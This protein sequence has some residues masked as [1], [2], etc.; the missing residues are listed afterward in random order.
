MINQKFVKDLSQMPFDKAARIIEA[1]GEGY[2]VDCWNAIVDTM[3]D[4][5]H[6]VA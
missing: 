1:L 3:L 6:E 2:G 4:R 5:A